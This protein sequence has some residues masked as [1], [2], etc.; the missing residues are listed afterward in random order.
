MSWLKYPEKLFSSNE[1]I[2]YNIKEG[3]RL[4]TD[5]NSIVKK[6]NAAETKN[7]DPNCSKL[8]IHGETSK[9]QQSNAS[10]SIQTSEMLA[11]VS[12]SENKNNTGTDH[13]TT[14]T[15]RKPDKTENGD[16]NNSGTIVNGSVLSVKDPT[17]QLESKE[18]TSSDNKPKNAKKQKKRKSNSQAMN[19]SIFC[20]K[21]PINPLESKENTSSGDKPKELNLPTDTNTTLKKEKLDKKENGEKN[22]S[23]NIV[24][25]NVLSVKNPTNRLESKENTTSDTKPKEVNLP[26]DKNT[27]L[28]DGKASKK[29][30]KGKNNT[31][32]M[33]TTVSCVKDPTNQ[34]ESKANT[35]SGSKP[36]GVTAKTVKKENEEKNNSQ[37]IDEDESCSNIKTKS[38]KKKKKKKNSSHEAAKNNFLH[39]DIVE[40]VITNVKS[41]KE[42]KSLLQIVLNIMSN[43]NM[44]NRKNKIDLFEFFLD[45]Y[46]Y[47][48]PNYLK[49]VKTTLTYCESKELISSYFV[50][51]N[52]VEV[53][54]DR[55]RK[56]RVPIALYFMNESD[57]E[58]DSDTDFFVYYNDVLKSRKLKGVISKNNVKREAA[59]KFTRNRDKYTEKEGVMLAQL[60]H[61]NIIELLGY[62]PNR[63][64]IILEYMNL[65]DLEEGLKNK[66]VDLSLENVKK[67]LID[68][69]TGME[70]V[71]SQKVLH[72]DL[73]LTHFLYND[74][75]EYKIGGF[76][77]AVYVGNSNG[78]YQSS[79]PVS[80]FKAPEWGNWREPDTF[81][82]T[83][84]TDVWAM[85]CCFEIILNKRRE[86]LCGDEITDQLQ[87]FV[88]DFMLAAYPESRKRFTKIKTFIQNIEV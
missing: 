64:L 72:R 43:E 75:N 47:A 68:L 15:K 29:E 19:N 6:D 49:K 31:Q 27:I 44:E 9:Q 3:I 65:F 5:N 86:T 23:R 20:I 35:S 2:K 25:G 79:V 58:I 14:L 39:L 46:Q 42:F 11:N 34:L 13:N 8:I 41:N 74:N 67:I 50:D 84:K 88:T 32:T 7:N 1:K 70:Y 4:P 53:Y 77:E 85:G 52:D 16:T 73:E 48:N 40:Q 60:K 71:H 62:E 17:N 51:E 45:N 26:T 66:K 18:N 37:T 63:K 54:T 24:N 59:I 83:Y 56:S 57:S 87:Q 12:T 28:K 80:M 30:Q 55:D 69:L 78:E 36:K 21:D 82:F 38:K 61:P 33:N 81:T 10:G 22:N 76:S